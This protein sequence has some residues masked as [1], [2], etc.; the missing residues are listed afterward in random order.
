MKHSYTAVAEKRHAVSAMHSDTVIHS[1]QASEH[2]S[3]PAWDLLQE[4]HERTQGPQAR[5]S[6][7]LRAPE[8]QACSIILPGQAGDR[9]TAPDRS[10]W[11]PVLAQI[12]QARQLPRD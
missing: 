9:R 3:K 4:F 11:L 5:A 6:V 10:S 2:A 8:A 7:L 1:K 12:C